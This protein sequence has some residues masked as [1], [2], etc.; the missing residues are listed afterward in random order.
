MI[1]SEEET[2]SVYSEDEFWN[3]QFAVTSTSPES[4]MINQAD[5]RESTNYSEA[6]SNHY[7]SGNKTSSTDY[8]HSQHEDKMTASEYVESIARGEIHFL[9]ELEVWRCL[10]G[11]SG[12]VEVGSADLLTKHWSCHLQELPRNQRHSAMTSLVNMQ[13]LSLCDL[14]EEI[15][16]GDI[17]EV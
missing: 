5:S 12:E 15:K 7:L 10:Y 17:Q 3:H 16:K 9:R 14:F 1:S 13:G 4:V 11:V 2:L 6:Q 8:L